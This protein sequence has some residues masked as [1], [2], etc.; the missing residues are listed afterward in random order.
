MTQ[1]FSFA[2]DDEWVSLG[3]RDLLAADV[4]NLAETT[5]TNKMYVSRF[6]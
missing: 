1:L 4:D 5:S 6:C 2:M 3:E